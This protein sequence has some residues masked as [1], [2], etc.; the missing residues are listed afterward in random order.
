MDLTEYRREIDLVDA[1]LVRLFRRRMEIAAD[2]AK[3]KKQAGLPVYQPERER[4]KLAA[5]EADAS[6]EIK[7]YLKPLYSLLFELSRDYQKWL[8]A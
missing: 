7:P 2:I 1:E 4:E 6:D 3:Y 8:G 5:L